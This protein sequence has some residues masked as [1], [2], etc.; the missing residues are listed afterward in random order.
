MIDY[1]SSLLLLLFPLQ[2]LRLAKR[3]LPENLLR[4]FLL[5]CVPSYS[6]YMQESP[7]SI[8]YT[9]CGSSFPISILSSLISL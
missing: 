8:R 4:V 1:I 5:T 9:I 7:K 6:L 3:K 2:L